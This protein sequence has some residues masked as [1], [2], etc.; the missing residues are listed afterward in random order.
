VNAADA[1]RHVVEALRPD[2][3]AVFTTGY[4]S[5]DAQAAGDRPGNFYMIGSMGLASAL[6]LG[7]ALRRPERRVFI[8]EGDG[9]LLMSLG[10]L[11]LIG[12]ESPAN[13]RHVIIDN[14]SYA[15]TGGQATVSAGADLGQMAA[16][17]GYRVI[18]RVTTEEALRAVVEDPESVGPAFIHVVV[19]RARGK[20]APRVALEPPE[21]A[22]RFSEALG[23]SE[24]RRWSIR[25]AAR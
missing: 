17:A 3:L 13:L 8:V 21:I 23:G 6:A 1:V 20:A 24:Q 10:T 18:R 16:A 11:A 7:V 22:R 2:D 15:S 5:R 19:E 9:S 14:Q 12:H 4:I 25:S